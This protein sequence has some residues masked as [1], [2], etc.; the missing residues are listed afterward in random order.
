MLKAIINY[1]KEL[2]KKKS[3]PVVIPL[4]KPIKY[5]KTQKEMQYDNYIAK[6]RLKR[7]NRIRVARLSRKINRRKK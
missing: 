6:K 4:P 5:I 3:P 7:N 2:F 1:L